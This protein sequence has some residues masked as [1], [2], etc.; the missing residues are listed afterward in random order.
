M[1]DRQRHTETEGEGAPRDTEIH[2]HRERQRQRGQW[3]SREGRVMGE[4][5]VGEGSCRGEGQKRKYVLA[6]GE[7]VLSENGHLMVCRARD[8]YVI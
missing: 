8:R 7:V 5:A 4:G 6:S 1:R 3:H 2:V